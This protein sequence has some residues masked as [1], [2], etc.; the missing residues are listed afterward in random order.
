M[1]TIYDMHTGQIIESGPGDTTCTDSYAPEPEQE[2]Q[3][4]LRLQLVAT[5]C[6]THK[7]IGMPPALVDVRIDDFLQ[8][9]D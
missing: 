4:G 7:A 2:R 8:Q 1:M 3:V 9:M 6:Q 5:T